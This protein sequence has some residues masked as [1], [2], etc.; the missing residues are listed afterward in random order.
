[1]TFVVERDV[2]LI[3]NSIGSKVEIENIIVVGFIMNYIII[4]RNSNKFSKW[5][6][7]I[8]EMMMMINFVTNRTRF[9]SLRSKK[10]LIFSFIKFAQY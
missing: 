5:I 8:M 10:I 6:M 3:R 9:E 1:M 2:I 4:H 7:A